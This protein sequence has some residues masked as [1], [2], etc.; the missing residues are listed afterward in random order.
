MS[1]TT[2]IILLVVVYLVAV[3]W[4]GMLSAKGAGRTQ[5]SFFVANRKLGWLPEGMSIYATIVSGAVFTGTV[6]LF[7]GAGIDM[8]GYG[9]GYA[10]LMPILYYLVG[11]QVRR[12]SRFHQ[13]QTQAEI[14]GD[15][16]N[17]RFLRAGAAFGGVLF[18]IPYF[19]VNAVAMGLVLESGISLPYQWGVFLFLI[20]TMSYAIVGGLRSVAFTDV[21]NGAIALGFTVVSVIVIGSL[22]GWGATF[23]LEPQGVLSTEG[24]GLTTY[25]TWFFYISLTVIALPDR[26]LRM[27]SVRDDSNL[28]RASILICVTL[29]LASFGYAILGLATNILVPNEAATDTV[30]PQAIQNFAPALLPFFIVTILATGMSTYNSGLLAASNIVTRDLWQPARR[31]A[32]ARSGKTLDVRT[33]SRENVRVG[34][35][36]MVV[37]TI[38]AFL[39]A[40]T[41]P[42]F[43]WDLV[44]ITLSFFLQFVPLLIAG[45]FW[46]RASRIAAEIA[47]VA[48]VATSVYWTFIGTSPFGFQAGLAAVIV[49][50]GLLILITLVRGATPAERERR[51]HFTR[52]GVAKPGT[53]DG[54]GARPVGEPG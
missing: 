40:G 30:L 8:L 38:F 27:V 42:P 34:R 52:A 54:V 22:A 6:G 9:L 4:I 25:L 20:V 50:A 7:Y 13:Y 39:V 51:K 1:M 35:V 29:G 15:M 21:A 11:S 33:R 3:V 23:E 24:P 14:F 41:Q 31:A 2:W 53:D 44:D 43:I 45:V 32:A 18:L 47:F 48:G 12:F 46:S 5:E 28:K 37:L 10:I 16:Y 19:A 26:M 36:L 49:N 17:S